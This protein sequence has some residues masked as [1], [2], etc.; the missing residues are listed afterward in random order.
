MGFAGQRQPV[1]PHSPGPA[2][3]HA[4]AWGSTVPERVWHSQRTAQGHPTP[5]R[6]QTL[7]GP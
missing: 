3:P 4:G 7:P 2:E 6:L 5:P 1:Q